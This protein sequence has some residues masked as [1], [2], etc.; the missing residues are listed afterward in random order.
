MEKQILGFRAAI[1]HKLLLLSKRFQV[2]NFVLL[3]KYVFISCCSG[4]SIFR[5]KPGLLQHRK[6]KKWTT[7]SKNQA[8]CAALEL[9]FFEPRVSQ[10]WA[11]KETNNK[12]SCCSGIIKYFCAAQKSPLLQG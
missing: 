10:F 9:S 6:N 2:F 7:P 3:V 1:K 11:M 5:S 8:F 12:N 4:I